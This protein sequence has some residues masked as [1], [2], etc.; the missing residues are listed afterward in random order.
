MLTEG[1]ADILS[2]DIVLGGCIWRAIYHF[3]IA[4][5]TFRMQ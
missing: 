1:E 4:A 2:R 5:Y 3:R